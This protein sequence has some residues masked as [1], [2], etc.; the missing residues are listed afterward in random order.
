M[1][2]LT[3]KDWARAAQRADSAAQALSTLLAQGVICIAW[4]GES[5]ELVLRKEGQQVIAYTDFGPGRQG[6]AVLG[7]AM[8][9]HG[10]RLV[11][12]FLASWY[13]QEC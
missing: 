8:P 7:S 5:Q 10:M 13:H 3:S 4:D 2:F 1:N 6:S 12:R 9:E 11:R